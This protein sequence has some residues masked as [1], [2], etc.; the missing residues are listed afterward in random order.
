MKL[1]IIFLV[2]FAAL[3]TAAVIKWWPTRAEK[4]SATKSGERKIIYY[5][6]AMHPWIK[7]DKPGKCPICG[8]NLV[9]VYEG[10]AGSAAENIVALPASSVSAV[11]V[12]SEAVR[13]RPLRHT[14]RVAGKIDDDDTRHRLLAAYTDGRIEKLSVNYVGAEV[15]AGEPLATFYSPDL[16]AAE[17]EFILLARP[18][19]DGEKEFLTAENSRMVSAVT[20]RLKLLGLAEAQIEALRKKGEADSF[21]EISA[22]MTG[23]VVARHAYEGQYVKAGDVLFE[24]G[25]FS[26]MWF[27][28]A[29]YERDLAWLQAGQA[30]EVSTPSVP[31]KIFH[32]TIAFIDPNLDEAT[33]SAK[34]RVEIANPVITT[35]GPPH[36]E[37]RHRLFAE[38]TVT[39]DAPDAL[40]VPRGAVLSPGGS[41]KVFV[42]LGDGHYEERKIKLGRA[43]DEFLEVIEGVEAGEKVVTAGNVLID[44]EAQLSHNQ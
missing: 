21:T 12:Q 30:V 14:V 23:T 16:L 11:G 15:K 31:G 44:A 9:P 20:Q 41:P 17:R 42:D 25:D 8:M 27:V 43:G 19:A 39:V 38:G 2:L 1:K 3:V 26:T 29:A 34:V 40:A 7:S 24:I 37:L 6:S 33:R 36:R 13:I 4:I 28:F 22:P 18:T 32:A 10:E 35:N 5:Q